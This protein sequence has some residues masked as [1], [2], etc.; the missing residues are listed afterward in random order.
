MFDKPLKLNGNVRYCPGNVP[1]F[2]SVLLN[3]KIHNVFLFDS[4]SDL[5][6]GGVCIF[7]FI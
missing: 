1:G 2:L 6:G 7:C 4:T 5:L 3:S